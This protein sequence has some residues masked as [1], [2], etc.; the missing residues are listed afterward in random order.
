[1][2]II[3]LQLGLAGILIQRAGMPGPGFARRWPRSC[4]FLQVED[5]LNPTT[6][7]GLVRDVVHSDMQSLAQPFNIRFLKSHRTLSGAGESSRR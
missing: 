2:W 3:G 4:L 5:Q 7:Q 1:M 6:R